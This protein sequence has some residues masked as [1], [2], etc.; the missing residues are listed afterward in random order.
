MILSHTGRNNEVHL[1]T[2]IC[3]DDVVKYVSVQHYLDI[4]L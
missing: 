4:I 1:C 2:C 3:D